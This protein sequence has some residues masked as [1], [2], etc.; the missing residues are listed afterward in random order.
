MAYGIDL[1]KA[2]GDILERYSD[3]VSEVTAEALEEVAKEATK[4]LRETSP[5]KTGA[6]AKGWT[7]EIQKGRVSSSATVYGRKK[8]Y[9]IAHLL[10]NGHALRNG[11]RSA[12]IVHIKPVEDWAV[13]ELE[14]QIVRKLGDII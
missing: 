1:Q 12:P 11:R 3:E 2:V 8:T 9:P 5:K 10:E 14:T 4:K 6:Y 13:G 7:Y